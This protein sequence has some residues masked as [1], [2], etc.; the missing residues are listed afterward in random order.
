M[1]TF[2]D[3]TLWAEGVAAGE[4]RYSVRIH[5]TNERGDVVRS[6]LDFRAWPIVLGADGTLY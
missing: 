5:V 1:T 6:R 4:S 2:Q 3:E